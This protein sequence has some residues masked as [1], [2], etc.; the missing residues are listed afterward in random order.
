MKRKMIKYLFVLVAILLMFSIT[1]C[2]INGLNGDIENA[3]LT[4]NPVVYNDNDEEFHDTYSLL[5]LEKD[6]EEIERQFIDFDKSV[7][8]FDGLEEG[9]YNL[10]VYYTSE[11]VIEKD[12]LIDDDSLNLGQIEI[13]PDDI[14]VEEMNGT[15]VLSFDTDEEFVN[16]EN[17]RLAIAHAI[18]RGEI[19]QIFVDN[20]NSPGE[21]IYDV[22]L[23]NR[24]SPP[25][26]V[27]YDEDQ[28][29]NLEFDIGKANEYMNNT[30]YDEEITLDFYHFDDD[31]YSQVVENIKSELEDVTGLTINPIPVED[32]EIIDDKKSFYPIALNFMRSPLRNYNIDLTDEMKDL[33]YD[34]GLNIDNPV[35][36]NEKILEYE[37]L[38]IEEARIIPVF[39]RASYPD[40]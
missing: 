12:I 23:A 13:E 15:F 38:I 36:F 28:K 8:E 1:G 16:D 35:V 30:N 22:K 21:W 39:Y 3:T 18:N 17:I 26:V 34:A 4:G 14:P 19:K 32:S 24:L 40:E 7:F 20:I 33:R 10:K 11:N 25:V 29:I 2:D 37:E 5:V 9:E 27:G 6:G 31:I